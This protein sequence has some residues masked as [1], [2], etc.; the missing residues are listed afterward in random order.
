MKTKILFITL[1]LLII[2]CSKPVEESILIYKDG[3]M[4]LPDTDEP[5]NG[6]VFSY[7]KNSSKFIKGKYENGKKHGKWIIT[8][9]DSSVKKIVNFT[10][11]KEDYSQ[12]ID[13]YFSN[14]KDWDKWVTEDCDWWIPITGDVHCDPNTLIGSSISFKISSNNNKIFEFDSNKGSQGFRKYGSGRWDFLPEKNEFQLYYDYP[15]DIKGTGGTLKL[16]SLDKILYN[17]KF[18]YNT[19]YFSTIGL[20]KQTSS[21]S[22]STS[23]NSG[24]NQSK[25]KSF[26]INRINTTIGST[27]FLDLHKDNGDSFLFYGSVYSSNY[28]RDVTVFI[29]IGCSGSSYSVLNVDVQL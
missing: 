29:L 26:A 24:C 19:K 18:Y 11:D 8:N 22:T 25:A 20:K 5:Y 27:Q 10:N 13:E 2:G 1:L 6:S 16:L 9:T 3:L 4:Y 7:K 28:S 14:S 12:Y 23:S 21:R 17:D 15:R